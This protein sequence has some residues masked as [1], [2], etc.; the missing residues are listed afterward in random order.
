MFGC[1]FTPDGQFIVSGSS[2]G[3]LQVWDAQYGH[4]VSML[5]LLEGHD[6]GVTSCEFSPTCGMEG[7]YN[8]LV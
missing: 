8:A 3:D 2:D 6:L 7:L 4:G 5:L 1:D